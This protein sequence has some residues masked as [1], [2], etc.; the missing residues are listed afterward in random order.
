MKTKEYD[1]VFVLAGI[2][3]V[4]Y[5]SGGENII[6]QLASRLHASGYKVSFIVIKNAE[7]YLYQ[8]KGDKKIIES[9]K[10]VRSLLFNSL[11]YNLNG[12]KII[13]KMKHIDYDF[14]I[15]NGIDFY[16]FDKPENVKLKIKRIIATAWITADFTSN[17]VKI[18]K[19]AIG[20][21]L[22]MHSEDDISF[23]G[24]LSIYASQT[25][26][27]SSLKKIVINQLEYKRFKNEK[28]LFFHVGFNYDKF[29]YNGEKSNSILFPLRRSESKGSKYMMEAAEILHDK[30][31]NWNL[32]AFG[33]VNS[34]LPNFI[35]FYYRVSTSNLKKLYASSKIFVL[36]SL[37]EGFSLSV[38]EAM[39]SGCAVV[40]TECRGVDEYMINNKN[41]LLVPIKDSTA[42]AN[43]V[44]KLAND[45][46]L[47]NT[48]VSEGQATAKNYTYDNMYKEFE[49]FF[50]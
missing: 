5:P 22:V 32:I 26:D 33:D 42:I 10:K 19:D 37:V 12:P 49:N 13:R 25:Y 46:N 36:P 27:L 23:S 41:G 48:I 34:G 3:V 6:Y 39:S 50:K 14:N 28:P 18:N 1:F 43:A 21:Y 47:F 38:L 11:F 20:Y 4:S 24:N 31:P 17:Y 2:P 9:R 16:F 15:L 40:S 45:K 44:I 30:L 8:I 35:E 7:K 29:Y